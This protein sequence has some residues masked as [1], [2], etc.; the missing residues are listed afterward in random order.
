VFK[1]PGG[2][3][4]GLNDEKNCHAGQALSIQLKAFPIENLPA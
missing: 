3:A 1:I 4:K 2:G